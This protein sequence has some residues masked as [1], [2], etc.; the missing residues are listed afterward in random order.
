MAKSYFMAVDLGTSFIKTAVYGSDGELVTQATSPVDQEKLRPGVFIQRGEKIFQSVLECIKKTAGQLDGVAVDAIAFTGQMAGFMGI[1]EHW[2]DVTTWSCSLDNRYLP[3]ADAMIRRHGDLLLDE[4]GTNSPVM[5]PKIKW[6]SHAF[7]D[8]ARRIK[9]YIMIS[10]YV[11]G[12]LG[13]VPAAEASIDRTYLEWTGLADI[14][15]DRW[16][17]KMLDALD[18]D[19]AHLP[20]IVPSTHVCGYLTKEMAAAT[21]LKSGIPLVSGAGDKPA[22][23]LGAAI[24]DCGDTILEAGSYGGMSCCVGEYRPDFANRRLDV[25]PS[26]IPGEFYAHYYIAGSGITL[27]WFME[28]FAKAAGDP[29]DE[30]E[31][32][33]AGL[34]PGTDGLMAVGMLGGRAMPLDGDMRGLWTGFNWSHKKEHFYHALLESFAY[35]FAA[36]TDI[37]DELY[38]ECA[39][40]PVQVIGGGSRISLWNQMHA[41]V[42]GRTYNTINLSDVALWGACVVAGK[43]AGVFDD[44]K[45]TA[46]KHVRQTRSFHCDPGKHA[47]Y[48]PLRKQYGRLLD[49]AGA[50]FRIGAG[51]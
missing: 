24:V 43:A 3:F 40:A 25:I 37:I 30:M 44:M 14:R 48:R 18:I 16:S 2:D 49:A 7:P 32:R 51:E 50:V 42:S 20:T 45:K 23:C 19:I 22:G 17:G 31:T 28:N 12:R 29:Y 38:P 35:E 15:R 8:E 13:G 10:G 27:D 26:A 21:G 33:A 39:G 47:A 9:K 6:F 41:D 4:A 34:A 5:A 1:D 11:L 46:K 36:T